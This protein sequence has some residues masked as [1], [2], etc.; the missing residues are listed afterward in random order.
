MGESRLFHNKSFNSPSSTAEYNLKMSSYVKMNSL[1]NAQ[2]AAMWYLINGDLS[3]RQ[4]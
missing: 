4:R 3:G 2:S 1:N